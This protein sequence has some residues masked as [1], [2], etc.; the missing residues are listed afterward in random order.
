VSAPAT[1]DLEELATRL[2][3]A[4][5]R[6]TAVPQLTAAISVDQAY[7]VQTRSLAR[8]YARGE[9]RIGIKMGF[10]SRAKMAQMGISDM[11]FGRLTDR[12]LIE[13]GAS[14]P[15]S[16]FVHPRVEPEVAFLLGRPLSGHID[17]MTAQ[18]AVAGVAPALEIIDSRYQDFKFSLPEVIAD[19]SSSSALVIGP[20]ADPAI[21]LDNLGL[22]LEIDGVARQVGS[23][24]AILGHPLFSLVAA[25][26]LLAAHGEQLDAGDI[27]M[28]GGATPAE[29]LRGGEFV[30]LT[31]Q[32]LGSV[33]FYLLAGAMRADE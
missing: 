2:D 26:R 27:V 8:R 31:L 19:N 7:E 5:R 12:M 14:V 10:T 13:P 11:I 3:E 33:S 18:A 32:K 17:P 25:A 23:T 15:R 21:S 29:A 24:A 16:R 6:A 30:Q 20:W 4:Q 9:R 22:Q 28:A 1:V